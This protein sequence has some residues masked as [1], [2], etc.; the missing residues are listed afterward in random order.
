MPGN[1]LS[2]EKEDMRVHV[3][4]GDDLDAMTK[5]ES[6]LVKKLGNAEMAA[7]N[8][9]RLNG[10]TDDLDELVKNI[11]LFPFGSSRRLVIYGDPLARITSAKDVERWQQILEKL[12][13]TAE[14]VLEFTTG[15]VRKNKNWMW[16]S[17]ADHAWLK[18]WIK[19]NETWLV[20]QEFRIP[21]KQEMP[22]RIKA[23]VEE[24]GGSIEERA[25]GELAQVVGDDILMLRQEVKKLC[26]YT[27]GERSIRVEDI[28]VLCSNIPEEDVFSMVD[29]FAQGNAKQ[30]LHHLKLMFANQE[31]V[32]VF[33]MVV[34]QFRLLLMAKEALQETSNEPAIAG[35]LHVHPY[36]V[37]KI[38]Q[39][40]RRFSFEQLEDIYRA[41]YDLDGDVKRGL[42]QPDVGLE[43]LFFEKSNRAAH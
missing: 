4:I 35:M 42:V 15:W 19:D 29:A 39:Q 11:S 27:N 3:F 21:S 34:R 23:M 25:A 8:I 24:E 40:S 37:K 18:K 17:Y 43:M 12:P 9:A 38:V 14:L 20:L 30:A 28:R 6:L 41:L 36:V 26:L 31:Y 16:G 7:F 33:A 13:P 22:A 2:P 32:Y 1:S 10:N 5:A